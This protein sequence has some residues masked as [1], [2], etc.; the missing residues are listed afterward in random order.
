LQLEINSGLSESVPAWL[1][2]AARKLVGH[3]K[4]S[5]NAMAALKQM[6]KHTNIPENHLIQDV[7]TRWDSTYQMFELLEEQRWTIYA[8][9]FDDTVSSAD[10][11]H[12]YLKDDQWVMGQMV[13]TLQIATTELCEAK[14]VANVTGLPCC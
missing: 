7:T 14:V 5:S 3:F 8:V 11:K 13:K 9:L 4:H 1:A 12:L 6:Q 10:Y 2:A